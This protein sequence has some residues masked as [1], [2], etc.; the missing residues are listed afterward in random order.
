MDTPKQ[1]DHGAAPGVG[2]GPSG[3]RAGFWIRFGA[4]LMDGTLIV[5]VTIPLIAVDVAVFQG[6][7]LV[8]AVIYYSM[9]E[10][11]PGGQTLGKCAV[12]IRV[13]DFATGGPIG[14]GRGLIRHLGRIVSGLV[15]LLGYLWMLWD[16]E[17]QTWHDKMTGAVVVPRRAASGLT[18][19]PR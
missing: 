7:S 18:S 12:G 16:R 4:A 5:V 11:G 10:G 1:A 9:L 3:P 19:S 17:Q 6:V 2:G 15:I 13:I 8:V 14:Y